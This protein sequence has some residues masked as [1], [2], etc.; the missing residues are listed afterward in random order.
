MVSCE[1]TLN[2]GPLPGRTHPLAQDQ[3]VT[4]AESGDVQ[5][6][7]EGASTL[8]GERRGLRAVG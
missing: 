5:V 3:R 8:V 2:R 6:E 1:G 7:A 4:A